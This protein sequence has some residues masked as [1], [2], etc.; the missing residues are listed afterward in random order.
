[1]SLGSWVEPFPSFQ[2]GGETDALHLISAVDAHLHRRTHKEALC[3]L[4]QFSG[5][6]HRRG[7]VDEVPRNTGGPGRHLR[8]RQSGL[9]ALRLLAEKGGGPNPR[10]R[11]D[12]LILVET[13]AGEGRGLRRLLKERRGKLRLQP[14]QIGTYRAQ[15]QL[16]ALR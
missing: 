6:E 11:R 13:V 7:L 10:P 16:L 8:L 15:P 9:I 3:R 14:P 1:M 2:K 4:G 5:G 12:R